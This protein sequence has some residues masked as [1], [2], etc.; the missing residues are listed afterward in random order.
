MVKKN[1]NGPDYFKN[2]KF[3]LTYHFNKTPG[4]ETKL[5]NVLQYCKANWKSIGENEIANIEDENVKT[6]LTLRPI[7]IVHYFQFLAYGTEIVTPDAKPTGRRRNSLL[8]YKRSI[9]YYMPLRNDDYD[10]F[11]GQGN[12]TKSKSINTLGTQMQN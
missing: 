8:A 12:P 3:F 7:N 6:L 5:A 11:T 10:V 2:L 4:N 1:T 9:S